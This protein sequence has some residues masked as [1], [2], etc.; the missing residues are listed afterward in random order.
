MG[1]K[2]KWVC[3][4]HLSGENN[5]PELAAETHRG[6]WGDRVPLMV[7]SRYGAKDVVEV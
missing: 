2:L 1:R 5:N 7:A 3:L 4:G 6:I